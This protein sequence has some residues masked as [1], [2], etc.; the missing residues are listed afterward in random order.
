MTPF[1]IRLRGMPRTRLLKPVTHT[2]VNMLPTCS[3]SSNSTNLWNI[4]YSICYCLCVYQV[5][6][7][8]A[9]CRN[10]GAA[11]SS[12]MSKAECI[13]FLRTKL[14]M[15]ENFRKIFSKIWGASGKYIASLSLVEDSNISTHLYTSTTGSEAVYG[16]PH[17]QEMILERHPISNAAYVTLT[18]Y[19]CAFKT[20]IITTMITKLGIVTGFEGFHNVFFYYID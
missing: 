14:G 5:K 1:A 2:Q 16:W 9:I 20:S 4:Y 6:T 15:P 11:D 10:H 12:R 17:L 7:L 8:Q 3:C 19:I 13:S 18:T